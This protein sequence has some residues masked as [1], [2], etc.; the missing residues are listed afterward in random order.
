MN[1]DELIERLER[2]ARHFAAMVASSED[3]IISKTL[4][5]TVVTCL[6]SDGARRPDSQMAL[7]ERK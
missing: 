2:D 3:A 4:D 6:Q 7:T 5:R 1:Q